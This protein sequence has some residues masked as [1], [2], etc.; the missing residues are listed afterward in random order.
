MRTCVDAYLRF[1]YEL[2]IKLSYCVLLIEV[3]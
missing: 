2:T 1:L 3:K